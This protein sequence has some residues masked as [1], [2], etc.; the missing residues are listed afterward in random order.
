[1][2]HLH[3]ADKMDAIAHP[4][5]QEHATC[6]HH[7]GGHETYAVLRGMCI[8]HAMNIKLNTAERI[9]CDTASVK[10]LNHFDGAVG[11]GEKWLRPAPQVLR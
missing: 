4:L 3:L 11:H 9:N 10:V 1:M 6:T 2:G 5:H 7:F 8:V